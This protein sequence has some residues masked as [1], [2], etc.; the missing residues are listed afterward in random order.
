MLALLVKVWVARVARECWC[1]A[2]CAPRLALP[3]LL[4][5][6]GVA[7]EGWRC[8][9]CCMVNAGVARVADQTKTI[10][11]VSVLVVCAAFFLVG[12]LVYR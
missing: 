12:A 4:V 2:C 3:V 7:G 9:C 8:S 1:C 6:P 11:S 5:N 10:V